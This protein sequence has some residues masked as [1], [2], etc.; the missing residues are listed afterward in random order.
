[1]QFS[2]SGVMFSVAP[3]RASMSYEGLC[4]FDPYLQVP[5]D[6]DAPSDPDAADAFFLGLSSDFCLLA[7]LT[8]V[9]F[10]VLISGLIFLDLP[11]ETLCLNSSLI[12]NQIFHHVTVQ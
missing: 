6:Q 12:F 4:A 1:M 9:A 5:A 10:H 3:T 2:H 7:L 11:T 8:Y